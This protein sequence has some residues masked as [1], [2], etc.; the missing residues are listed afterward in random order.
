VVGIG[1]MV[2]PVPD[3]SSRL[4]QR[5]EPFQDA[6]RAWYR[7]AL[8]SDRRGGWIAA[9]PVIEVRMVSFSMVVDL[10]RRLST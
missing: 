3:R 8:G 7:G 5:I 1:G 2:A 4:A 10:H 6:R 9:N